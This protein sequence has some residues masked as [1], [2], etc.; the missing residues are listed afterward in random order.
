MFVHTFTILKFFLRKKVSNLF[1][2]PNSMQQNFVMLLIKWLKV[3]FFDKSN[4]SYIRSLIF[5]FITLVNNNIEFKSLIT[6]CPQQSIQTLKT[7]WNFSC[8]SE[9]FDQ[10]IVAELISDWS[11]SFSLIWPDQYINTFQ[12]R[13]TN[14]KQWQS[15]QN[16]L[17]P[18]R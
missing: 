13:S 16:A 17:I 4:C 1:G 3:F 11:L 15:A 12:T 10:L 14:H 2:I 6:F 9:T 18:I 5:K 8:F 7:K